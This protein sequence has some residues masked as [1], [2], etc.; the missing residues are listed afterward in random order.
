MQ[1]QRIIILLVILVVIP[2][3]EP[4]RAADAQYVPSAQ[5]GYELLTS[6]A[7]LPADFDQQVFEDLWKTWPKDLRDLAQK[8]TPEERRRMT[9]S[10]YG[11]IE[12]PDHP[13]TGTAWGHLPNGQGGWVMNCLSCHGGKVA[14]KA[15]AGLPNSHFGLETLTEDVRATK[16][17]QGKKLG[18]M[19]LAQLG[20]PLGSTHG[21]TNSVMFGVALEALRDADMKVYRNRL[22]PPMQHHDLD[23][24]PFWNV[25]RKSRLYYDGLVKKGHRPI[26]QFVLL[27]KNDEKVLA[28]WE[29]DFRD[30]LAWIES[31]EAPKYPWEI[32]AALADSGQKVFNRQCALCHGTYG[33]NEH[34][35]EKIIALDRLGTDPVRLTSLTAEY[36]KEFQHSWLANYDTTDPVWLPKGYVA[37]PL[38]GIWASGPYLHNGSVPTLWHVLHPDQRPKVWKRTED[39]YDREKLGLEIITHDSLPDGVTGADRRY[40]FDTSRPGKSAAGHRFPDELTE[41]EKRAI[42]EY[43]K[44]L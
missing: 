32:D 21:T 17:R 33:A 29:N 20:M 4:I 2:S 5:R 39:G 12:S 36:R 24:P 22:P 31:L 38:N 9:F 14:G 27:P 16:I 41:E 44:T 37:P 19:D 18:H 7:F 40:Y 35:P 23:A 28:S 30:I 11:L 8:A 42:L 6:K 13:G 10:R 43:L 25:K 3:D 26:I 15:I 34:Y 1:L